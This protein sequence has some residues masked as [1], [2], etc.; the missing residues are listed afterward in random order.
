MASTLL[1]AAVLMLYT[2]FVHAVPGGKHVVGPLRAATDVVPFSRATLYVV[3]HAVTWMFLSIVAALI[4]AALLPAAQWVVPLAAMQIAGFAI[5][6]M[7]VAR[8]TMGA[9]ILLPQWFLLGPLAILLFACVLTPQAPRWA[10][11]VLVGFI[12]LVHFA[13]AAGLTWPAVDRAQLAQYVIGRKTM[14]GRVP[15]AI[16]GFG[17]LVVALLFAS[18]SEAAALS[19]ARG[20]VIAIFAVRGVGGLFESRVRAEIV[21]TPYALYSRFMYSPLCLVLAAL[22]ALAIGH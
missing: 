9:V 14:P 1:L 12:A 10:L 6:F 19:S 17:L 21:G 22:G 7:V 15:T 11:V 13:W 20:A 2:T 3:W 4:A 16:V 5:V 8:R 18:T